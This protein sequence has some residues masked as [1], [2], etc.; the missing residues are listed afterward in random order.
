MHQLQYLNNEST[1]TEVSII[2][3]VQ[4]EWEKLAGHLRFSDSAIRNL[5][6]DYMR[7]TAGNACR[8][9]FQHW[10]DGNGREPVDWH[11]VKTVLTEM[12]HRKLASKLPS[13]LEEGP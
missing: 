3:E 9:V 4:S 12:G 2:E 8:A 13:V 1:D 6:K 10:L 5:R 11:T 7:D